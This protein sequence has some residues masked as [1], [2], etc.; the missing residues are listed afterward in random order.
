MDD[1]AARIAYLE[2]FV[3]ERRVQRMRSVLAERT[4]YITVAL[5]EIY[6][7]HN[8]SAVLRS[9]DSLGVQDVHIVETRNRYR[10]NPGVELG[11]AQWL[12]LY[13]YGAADGGTIT[14]IETLRASGYRIVATS[15]HSGQVTLDE[16]DLSAGPAALL[17]GTELDGLSRQALDLAD[18]YLVIPM[19][20]FVESF[21]ISVSAAIILHSLMTGLRQSNL[22]YHLPEDEQDAILLEWLRGSVKRAE[23]LE[24]QFEAQEQ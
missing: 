7:P 12:S 23:L 6:Q 13:R 21:N 22:D 19:F 5:E 14:A 17:F 24:Q 16:F 2:Q 4:R 9:C 18:E 11:T 1:R 20:G 8:A 3:S 10:V 15:P